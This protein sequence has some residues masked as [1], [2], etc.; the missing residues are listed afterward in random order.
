M[1][2][3]AIPSRMRKLP[4]Y[5]GYVIPYTTWIEPSTGI[6]D[7]KTNDELRRQKVIKQRRCA[8]CG[9]RMNL[10][11]AFIGGPGSIEKG[12]MFV[13]AGMHPAC[14]EYAWNVCPYIVYGRGHAVLRGLDERKYLLREIPTGKMERMGMM[15]TRSYTIFYDPKGQMFVKAGPPTSVKWRT[16]GSAS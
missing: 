13:D 16:Y 12:Q 14:A 9:D 11:I 3:I 15:I 7:F 8:V 2:E 1:T 6:P 10:E 4:R 5:Q